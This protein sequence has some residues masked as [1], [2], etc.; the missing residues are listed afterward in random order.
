MHA[1]WGLN[2]ASMGAN[3]ILE[4]QPNDPGTRFV[5]TEHDEGL[6]Y[7]TGTNL[8]PGVWGGEQGEHKRCVYVTPV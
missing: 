1:Q 7:V 8:S 2:L 4:H 5:S 6:H 3:S